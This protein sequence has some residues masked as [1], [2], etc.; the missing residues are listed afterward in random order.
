MEEK[1]VHV[2]YADP[3]QSAAEAGLRYIPDTGKGFTR[4]KSGKGFTYQDAKGEKITDPKTIDRINKLIIPPAWENVW[5]CL[6]PTKELP[7]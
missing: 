4:R 1:D 7:S 2:L 5:I 3:I 6:W